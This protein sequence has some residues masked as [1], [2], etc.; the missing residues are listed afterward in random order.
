MI[1]EFGNHVVEFFKRDKPAVVAQFVLI[2]GFGQF[3][4]FRSAGIRRSTELPAFRSTF[5]LRPLGSTIYEGTRVL[6]LDDGLHYHAP[7]RNRPTKT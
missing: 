7:V 3:R 1:A 5:P 6:L 4:D 2:H